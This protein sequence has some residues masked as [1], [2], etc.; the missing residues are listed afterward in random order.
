MQRYKEKQCK[1]NCNTSGNFRALVADDACH[2]GESVGEDCVRVLALPGTHSWRPTFP[3]EVSTL[4][5]LPW[6]SPLQVPSATH[7]NHADNGFLPTAVQHPS[8]LA[9]LWA[10]RLGCFSTELLRALPCMSACGYY[11]YCSPFY[12]WH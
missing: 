3:S 10:G 12:S 7:S 2:G 1:D 8:V 9:E 4:G 5:D 6:V 11:L